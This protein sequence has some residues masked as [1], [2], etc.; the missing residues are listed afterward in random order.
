MPVKTDRLSI[1][2]WVFK[3]L[4]SGRWTIGLSSPYSNVVLGFNPDSESTGN[5]YPNVALQD[6]EGDPDKYPN[7]DNWN[8]WDVWPVNN[9]PGWHE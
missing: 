7:R 3:K 9:K 8:N 1:L 2:Q 5:L 6:L 4:P